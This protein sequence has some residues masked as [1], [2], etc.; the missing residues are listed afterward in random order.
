METLKTTV[1]IIGAGPSGLLLSQLLH[2]AGID[3]LIVERTSRARVLERIRAGVLERGTV[4]GM[5]EAGCAARLHAECI[6]HDGVILSF[7]GEQFEIPVREITGHHVIVYGQT[8]ITKDL[9]EAC[10]ARGQAIYWEC[11]DAVLADLETAV[12]KVQFTTPE[13]ETRRIEAE[14]VAGCDGFHGVCR[15]SI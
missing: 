14:I 6:P 2:Q 15:Q 5:E 8:E 1:A 4:E 7:D 13:G 11:P 9:I 12:P 3:S 10:E